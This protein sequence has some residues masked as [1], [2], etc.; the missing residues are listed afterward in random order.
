MNPILQL[1]GQ[2]LYHY[3]RD[4]V[5]REAWQYSNVPTTLI[6]HSNETGHNKFKV[7]ILKE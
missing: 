5:S 6:F 4:E 3:I 2:C 7:I 1:T